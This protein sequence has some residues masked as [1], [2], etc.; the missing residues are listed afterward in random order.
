[1]G[2]TR[3]K[4]REFIPEGG[5]AQ[6]QCPGDR[7]KALLLP[8]SLKLPLKVHAPGAPQAQD[9]KSL[10]SCTGISA[11]SLPATSQV[12]TCNNEAII[13]RCLYARCC[14]PAPRGPSRSAAAAGRPAGVGSV[15]NEVLQEPPRPPTPGD[16]PGP[17]LPRAPYLRG[18]TPRNLGSCQPRERMVPIP[19]TLRAP[20]HS[21]QR[22]SIPTQTAAAHYAGVLA[23]ENFLEP[24]GVASAEPAGRVGAGRGGEKSAPR[25]ATFVC[26]PRPSPSHPRRIAL[27]S[28]WIRELLAAAQGRFLSQPP[29]TWVLGL[30]ILL[31][32]VEAS[33]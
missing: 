27:I 18:R 25:R 5:P 30:M 32:S 22:C 24:R 9:P 21:L 29:G 31:T 8:F 28:L 3:L 10:E 20:A 19:S 1:M 4:I 15:P 2:K 33:Q 17:S 12:P 16:W 23:E 13:S 26:G 6:K 11:G 7:A 14:V